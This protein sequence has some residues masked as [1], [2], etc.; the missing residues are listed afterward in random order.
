M[1]EEGELINMNVYEVSLFKMELFIVLI[2]IIF[3]ISM[4]FLVEFIWGINIVVFI[5]RLLFFL[6]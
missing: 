1:V 5:L 2:G 3:L 6:R 4:D